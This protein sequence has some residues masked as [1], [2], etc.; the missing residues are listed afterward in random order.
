MLLQGLP[1]SGP[2]RSDVATVATLCRFTQRLSPTDFWLGDSLRPSLR[3]EFGANEP[4]RLL[5]VQNVSMVEQRPVCGFEYRFLGRAGSSNEPAVFA[6]QAIL[7][8]G[9]SCNDLTTGGRAEPGHVEVAAAGLHYLQLGLRTNPRPA[10]L[11]NLADVMLLARSLWWGG[12]IKGGWD[13]FDA[14]EFE[15]LLA[16]FGVGRNDR[17]DPSRPLPQEA[18]TRLGQGLK[19]GQLEVPH[20]SLRSPNI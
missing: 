18:S 11:E 14:T 16:E 10:M 12:F 5:L 3:P 1:L 8:E 6:P 15:K 20:L 19:S 4:A 9:P 13:D 2:V 17:D 7:R